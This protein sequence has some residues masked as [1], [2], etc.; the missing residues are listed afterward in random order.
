[1]HGDRRFKSMNEVDEA[2]CDGA[3]TPTRQWLCALHVDLVERPPDPRRLARWLTAARRGAGHRELAAELLRSDDYCRAQV[4]ALHRSLLDRDPDPANL[5]AWTTALAAGLALQDVIAGLCDSFEYK[6]QHPVG[7]A[8]VES[9]YQRLLNRASDP[10]GKATWLSILDQRSSTLSVIRRFLSGS[11]YCALRVTE[12]HQRL[13]GREPDQTE[14]P[15]RVIGLVQGAPLQDIVLR[16][17]TSAEYVARA[18][19]R[20]DLGPAGG[21]RPIA[22]GTTPIRQRSEDPDEDII[23]LVRAGDIRGACERLTLRHG[24]SVYRYCRVALGDA[25]LADDIHQQVFIEALRDL[26]RFAGRSTVR[27]WLFG[28]ARHRVLDGAKRRRRARAHLEDA[29]ASIAVDRP[30][31][32]PAPGEQIDESRLLATLIECVQELE[33]PARTSV[34]LRYQQ[35]LSYEEMA[36]ISGESPG[37]LQ[38]RVARALRRLRDLIE[39]RLER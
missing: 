30:D 38:A 8:F 22:R 14:L 4:L 26:P 39:A 29:G 21:R 34:L 16:F 11:E 27:T 23:E 28:I 10:D 31:P 35:G 19:A 5:E 37:T 25:A 13:L 36:E 17:A 12:I 3:A 1:M 33:D 24:T 6:T 15:E 9:L 32:H 20:T 18:Q 7:P 2:D